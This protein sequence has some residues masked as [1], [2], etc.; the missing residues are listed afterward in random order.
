[1]STNVHYV[2][3]LVYNPLDVIPP[4][5]RLELLLTL[6]RAKLPMTLFIDHTYYEALTDDS[7]S[8]DTIHPDLRLVLLS[9]EDTEVWKRCQEA[10][11][12]KLPEVRNELKDGEFFM[13]LMNLKSE[14]VA[15]VSKEVDSPFVGFL[16]AG[17]VKVFKDVEGSLGRLKNLRMRDG[18]RGVAVP[19]CWPVVRTDPEI[20][21]K[22]I[23]WIFCGGFFVVAREDAESFSRAAL[24][25]LSYFLKEKRLT[26]EVNVWVHM[27]QDP[28]APEM[29]W[30]VA[31]HDDRMTMFPAEFLS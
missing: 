9:L 11:V 8:S 6:L 3:V 2:S 22:R 20:L 28:E 10:G 21:A 15:R 1:M 25:A 18:F 7:F 24:D 27:L 4:M 29:K 13:K 30:F 26:W 19:G 12:L 17:I 23:C 14:L 31:D 5:K 16:D